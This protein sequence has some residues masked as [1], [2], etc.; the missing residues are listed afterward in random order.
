VDD[1]KDNFKN[2][3]RFKCVG[4]SKIFR[5]PMEEEQIKMIIEGT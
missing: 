3:K 4:F 2:K 1:W 5:K